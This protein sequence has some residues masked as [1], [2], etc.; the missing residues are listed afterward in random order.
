MEIATEMNIVF[1][2]QLMPMNWISSSSGIEGLAFP[3]IWSLP[4]VEMFPFHSFVGRFTEMFPSAPAEC[5]GM[6]SGSIKQPLTQIVSP[7]SPFCHFCRQFPGQILSSGLFETWLLGLGSHE[8]LC[9]IFE[10]PWKLSPS[11]FGHF[12]PKKPFSSTK[13]PVLCPPWHT[14]LATF[15]LLKSEQINLGR[16]IPP[17]YWQCQK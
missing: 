9:Y 8:W 7:V 13:S 1:I 10:W 15:S 6:S 12:C 2:F 16:V 4:Q 17:Q 5:N 3:K 11:L 14:I